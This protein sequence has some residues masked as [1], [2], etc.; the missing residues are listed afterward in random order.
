[1]LWEKRKSPQRQ[2]RSQGHEAQA[3]HPDINLSSTCLL[4]HCAV[5]YTG[6]YKIAF[7]AG[8]LIAAE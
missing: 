6:R 7:I 2:W 4:E 8:F 1:M 3:P 5:F